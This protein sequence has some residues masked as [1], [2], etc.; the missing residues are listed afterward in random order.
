MYT[1]R[2]VSDFFF[3]KNPQRMTGCS[4]TN[5]LECRY[6]WWERVRATL[7]TALWADVNLYISDWI[8]KTLLTK[9]C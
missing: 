9:E 2:D 8:L 3:L 7:A 6:A 4:S 5:T 1:L